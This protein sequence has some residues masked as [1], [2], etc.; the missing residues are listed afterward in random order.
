[1]AELHPFDRA[2][3]FEPA[4]GALRGRTLPE[5]ANMVGPFG[6]ITAAAVLRAIETHPDRRGEPLALTVNYLAP[7]VDGE[8]RIAARA[9][10]TNRSNQHWQVEL[11]QDGE[12]KTTATA[13]FAAQR[14]TWSD[15]ELMMPEAS[16]PESLP[17]PD[18]PAMVVWIGNYD[19]RFVE[20]AIPGPDD[21]PNPS[22]TTTLWVRDRRGRALDHAA[23]A[24]QCD[25]FYPRTFLRLGAF[26][27]AG[28][29]SF[30][31]Y[32][33]ADSAELAAVGDD[34]VLGSTRANRFTGG[35]FDQ[36]AELWS[37]SGTLLATTH[38]LVYYKA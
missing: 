23:L 26:G 31:V 22:S 30:T 10:R 19:L 11:S 7:I 9:V 12:P 1:M 18:A 35:Y 27:P 8:F 16:A 4:D 25:I 15:S 14:D 13:V 32:F 2:M 38:Q 24:A 6:G 37:R 21:G 3:T 33:H 29:I 5:W 20:G 36:S 34:Y 17:V 28:T